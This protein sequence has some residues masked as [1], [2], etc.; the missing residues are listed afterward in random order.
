MKISLVPR[1]APSSCLRIWVGILASQAPSL[2]WFLDGNPVAAARIH[3]L[4]PL[5]SAI[6][7]EFRGALP[8]DNF[9]GVFEIDGL[10][11]GTAYKISLSASALGTTASAELRTRT[12]PSSVPSVLESTFNVLLASCFYQGEDKAGLAGIFANQLNGAVRPDLTLLLGDQVYLD[13]PTLAN[14]PNNKA[15]LARRFES[16]YRANWQKEEGY[17]Q[18]FKVAPTAA[19]PDDHEYW[20]NFPHS[21]PFIQNS[22]TQSGRDNWTAAAAALYKAFQF[23]YEP[24]TYHHG[25]PAELGD[26]SVIN[27]EPLSFFMADGRSKRDPN[28]ATI[29]TARARKQLDHWISDTIQQRRIGVFITGQSMLGLPVGGLRGR[30]ADYQ[31]ANYGDFSDLTNALGR[32]AEAGL[33]VIMITGDVHWGRLAAARDARTGRESIFEIISSPTSLVSTVAKDQLLALRGTI[34][35]QT[36]AWP[37]HSSPGPVPEFLWFSD[38][39]SRFVCSRGHEQRGN[40]F[41]L[42]S[43]TRSGAGINLR[44]TY[45]PIHQD[46][47]QRRPQAVR[48]ISLIPA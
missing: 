26:A 21:S 25:G 33:P 9:T 45:Y 2:T 7:V 24:D 46:F 34:A 15:A 48:E 18:L 8:A 36:E 27:V 38:F 41:V 3:P 29:L 10:Q 12:L 30:V 43:F 32:L 5:A 4:R 28:L 20:N 11:S 1:A 42:L 13:L 19:I 31:L 35:G 6:P 16:S 22:W 47:S 39:G 40:H 23:S 37:R 44:T 14:F 17:S